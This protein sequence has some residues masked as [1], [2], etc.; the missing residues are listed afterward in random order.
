MNIRET[1]R[2]TRD[3]RN[4]LTFVFLKII[5]C[6]GNNTETEQSCEGHGT[7]WNSILRPRN[8]VR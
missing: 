6:G 4:C 7:S 3:I 8:Y 2:G 1:L 5:L